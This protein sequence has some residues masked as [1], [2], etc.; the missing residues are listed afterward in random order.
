MDVLLKNMKADNRLSN[1]FL[2]LTKRGTRYMNNMAM[3]Q[4]SNMNF[5]IKS[6][7]NI[8]L[9]IADFIPNT[10]KNIPMALNKRNLQL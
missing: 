10:I 8:G 7:L 3:R 5:Y 9:Q 1:H 2:R 6:D 4:I